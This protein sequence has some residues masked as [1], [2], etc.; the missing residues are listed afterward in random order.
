MRFSSGNMQWIDTLKHLIHTVGWNG[1]SRM[2][3]ITWKYAIVQAL[4][5]SQIHY[6]PGTYNQRMSYVNLNILAYQE[7][8]PDTRTR[9]S[10]VPINSMS[11]QKLK[12]D[13]LGF[14]L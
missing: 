9:N 3:E 2:T 12:T 8:F 7:T 13:V 11:H 1:T 4:K 10:L 6:L 14:E 5:L